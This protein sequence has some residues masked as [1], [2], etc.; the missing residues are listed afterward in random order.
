MPD[1][2]T[3]APSGGGL[4]SKLPKPNPKWLA[5]VGTAI[6]AGLI[7]Y[8]SGGKVNPPIPPVP[9]VP[10]FGATGWVDDPQAVTATKATLPFPVFQDTP[11]GQDQ[12]P[13]PKSVYLWEAHRKVTGSLPK[14]HNQNPVGSCVSFG[15]ARAI[16][17]SLATQI[18]L[19][20]K[21]EFKNV[22]EEVVYAGSRIDVGQ[23]RIRGDGSVGAWAAKYVTE[24]GGALPRGVYGSFDLSVYEPPRCRTWGATGSPAAIREEAKKYPVGSTTQVRSWAEAKKALASGYGMAICSNRGFNKP[25]TPYGYVNPATRDYRGVCQPNGEWNHCMCLDGYHTDENGKEFGHIENS[26]GPNAHGGPVGWGE[27]N[28]SGFWADSSVIDGM[29]K[30]NDS[31]AFSAVKGFP[32]RVVPVDWFAAAPARKLQHS[33]LLALAW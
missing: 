27:P 3:P 15:T 8:L 32:A 23:G 31:W 24:V 20:D 4:F 29:L 26:W 11:A 25:G 16:E 17:R 9:D 30:Q 7:G 12:Q 10:I 14:V 19:G 18:A 5:W 13:L 22:A 6:V 21:F 28:T 33:P 1:E 2:T